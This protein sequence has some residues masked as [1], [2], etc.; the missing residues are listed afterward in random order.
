MPLSLIGPFTQLI[1]MHQLPAKG[2]L[3]DGQLPI[4]LNGGLLIDDY[5][6]VAVD[7]FETLKGQFVEAAITTIEGDT[8]AL[9]GFIDCHTHLAWAGSRAADF[10]ARNAGVS[11]QEIAAAGGGIWSTVTQTRKA[12]E[13]Q[14]VAL[15]HQRM[16]WL[17]KNGITTVEIKSGYGLSVAEELKL[18]R[19][20]N[21]LQCTVEQTVV[22]TCLAAH[23]LPKDFA[24]NHHDYLKMLINEL[25]PQAKKEKLCNRFDIFIEEHAFEKEDALW[26]LSKLR[27]D[28][29]DI[30]VHGDQFTT[31]GSSVAV[32]VG[33]KSVDHLEVSTA[34]E[35]AMIAASD[36]VAVALP[37]A[38]LGLGYSYTPARKLL[39]AGA[40][41]AIA[42]DW[43]PGSAPMGDLLVQASILATFEKLSAAEVLA[44]ITTRAAH[45]LGLSNK[46]Q[47]AKNF[48]AD[49]V[50]FPTN[51]FREIIYQMGSMKPTMV[52]VNG[53]KMI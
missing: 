2:A 47:L 23:T 21:A 13:Q 14:L 18:L 12:T 39:D 52:W 25:V 35:I 31:G 42:S 20:I 40:S 48:D 24:C 7:D 49:I 9:P 8:V 5:K 36:T 28:G 16:N 22:P 29:F 34:K 45:A 4:I 43:N 44:G 37:G 50:A 46:G 10:A 38:S 17:L 19:S 15:M 27:E 6:I 51:D 26:Y 30:T 41:L 1:T 53:K 33:A 11:Y 3:H 32:N